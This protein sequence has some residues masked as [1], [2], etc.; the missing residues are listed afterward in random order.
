LHKFLGKGLILCGK[1]G[2]EELYRSVADTLGLNLLVQN[3][4]EMNL[5]TGN[6][7]QIEGKLKQLMAQA[8]TN[9]PILLVLE[10][11][12]VYS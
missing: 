2:C 10:N 8:T 4:R 5:P 12:E 6:V 7:G 3:C 9:I 1:V 11:I